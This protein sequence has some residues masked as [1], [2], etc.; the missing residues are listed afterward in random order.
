MWGRTLHFVAIVAMLVPLGAGTPS[1]CKAAVS[2]AMPAH[3]CCCG[4]LGECKCGPA[5]GSCAPKAPVQA[6]D[7]A[8]PSAPVKVAGLVAANNHASLTDDAAPSAP[9]AAAPE[10]FHPPFASCPIYLSI[11]HLRT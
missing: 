6:P 9:A 4:G 10:F 1:P 3:P 7:K 8:P 5:T 11:E 2:A